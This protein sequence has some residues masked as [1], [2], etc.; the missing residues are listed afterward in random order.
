MTSLE[1]KNRHK[2]HKKSYADGTVRKKVA[3]GQQVR[4]SL[5]AIDFASNLLTLSTGMGK[6]N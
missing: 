6:E 1:D 2:N 4:V 3:F 5:Y